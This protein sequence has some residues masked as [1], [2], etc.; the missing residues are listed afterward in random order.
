MKTLQYCTRLVFYISTFL[1][2]SCTKTKDLP[3]D[4]IKDDTYNYEAFENVCAIVNYGFADIN[5][6]ARALRDGESIISIKRGE[7]N[8][9]IR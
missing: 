4:T 8:V 3:I 7:N 9:S 2:L 6:I 1:M 5:A